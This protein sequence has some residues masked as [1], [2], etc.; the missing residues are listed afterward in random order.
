MK[1]R[2]ISENHLYKKVYAKGQKVFCKHTVVYV[3][4]DY[5][6]ARLARENPLKKKI[7]RIGLA[8]STKIGGAVVRS[9]IRR[10]LRA[11]YRQIETENDV[12]KGYLIVLVAKHSAADAKS[13]D[14]YADLLYALSK[15][16]LLPEADER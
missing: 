1:D 7:N 13:Q 15:M 16:G 9:R 8:V 4:T 10:I 2:A 5:H 6:A 11:A 3:L 12:K 14:I